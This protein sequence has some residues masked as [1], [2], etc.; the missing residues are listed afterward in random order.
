M[1][2]RTDQAA[3]ESNPGTTRIGRFAL[4]LYTEDGPLL[5]TSIPSSRKTRVLAEPAPVSRGQGANGAL[6]NPNPPG[7]NTKIPSRAFCAGRNEQQALYE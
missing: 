6:S 7:K 5:H 3:R 4:A 2:H 1:S